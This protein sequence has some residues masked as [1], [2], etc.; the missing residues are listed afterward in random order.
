MLTKTSCGTKDGARFWNTIWKRP[1]SNGLKCKT[2]YYQ[3]CLDRH[4]NERGDKTAI[5]W[6]PNDP[7]E[8]A[9]H[10]TYKDL[11]ERVCKMAN[12][13]TEMGVQKAIVYAYTYL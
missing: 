13:L 11:H 2:K 4:L 1:T 3:N 12:V 6:E 5:I 8:E 10:I 9:Q 7:K